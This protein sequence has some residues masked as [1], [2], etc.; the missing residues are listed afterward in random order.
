[1]RAKAPERPPLRN[2]L[3]AN[4]KGDMNVALLDIG[5][6]ETVCSAV[7][8]PISVMAWHRDQLLSN[9]ETRDVGPTFWAWSIT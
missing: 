1:M 3:W 4:Q 5:V 9:V 6:G 2:N 7:A 8:W